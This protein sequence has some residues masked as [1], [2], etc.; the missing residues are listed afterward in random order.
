MPS[1]TE[2]KIL[3]DFCGEIVSSQTR[4][5][6]ASLI[7]QLHKSDSSCFLN[8]ICRDIVELILDCEPQMISTILEPI[9]FTQTLFNSNV[10]LRPLYI[11]TETDS[12]VGLLYS[13]RANCWSLMR[14]SGLFNISCCEMRFIQGIRVV[15][16]TPT[17]V[18]FSYCNEYYAIQIKNYV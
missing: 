15:S 1:S 14:D 10:T 5:E 3:Y 13:D 8:V 9:T 4:G 6:T 12:V 17:N 16:F 18:I 7:M 11:F 2:K